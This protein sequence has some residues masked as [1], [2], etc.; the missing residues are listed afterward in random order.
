MFQAQVVMSR[1]PKRA[2]LEGDRPCDPPAPPCSVPVNDREIISE[3]ATVYC[4][5]LVP[6]LKGKKR[7]VILSNFSRLDKRQGITENAGSPSYKERGIPVYVYDVTIP[8]MKKLRSD[9][10]I[11]EVFYDDFCA[12]FNA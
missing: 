10:D 4:V 12:Q 5:E 7:Y 2:N 8:A 9:P 1:K 3:D 6:S 11:K